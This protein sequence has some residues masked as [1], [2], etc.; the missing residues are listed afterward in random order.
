MAEQSVVVFDIALD[1]APITDLW[2]L[3]DQDERARADRFRFARDRSRFVAS[4]G[5]LR[6]ILAAEL[7]TGANAIRIG[8][9]QYGKPWLLDA[10]GLHFSLSHS[11]DRGL[12]ALSFGVAVGVDLELMRPEIDADAMATHF[13]SRAERAE[14]GALPQELRVQGF[15]NGWT[16]KEAYLKGHGDGIAF[17]LDHFDVTLTPGAPAALRADRRLGDTAASWSL[18]DLPAPQGFAAALA[19]HGPAAG[20]MRREFEWDMGCLGAQRGTKARLG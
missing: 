9:G 20:V 6:L 2:S 11:G 8:C 13:F 16:R 18:T 15:F 19:T 4:H 7:G 12:I 3:L 5:V 1:N 10:P 17:G 14:L